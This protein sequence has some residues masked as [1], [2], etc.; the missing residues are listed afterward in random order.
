LITD[1]AELLAVYPSDHESNNDDEIVDAQNRDD[2]KTPPDGQGRVRT[3]NGA[4]NMKRGGFAYL[5]FLYGSFNGNF[6]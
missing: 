1:R 5:L 6:E 3:T 4:T 2:D